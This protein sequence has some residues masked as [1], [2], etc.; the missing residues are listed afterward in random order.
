M[1]F[2]KTLATLAAGFAA[3]RGV[4]QFRRMGGMDGVKEALRKAGDPGGLADDMAAMAEKAGVP[5]GAA[6]V[7][8]WSARAS[9]S[10]LGGIAAAEMGL[11][12][13]VSV[14]ARAAGT[15]AGAA[16]ALAGAA[17]PVLANLTE[18]ESKLMIRAMAEAA[19]A[20]GQIDDEE[21]RRLMD[22][23]ADADPAERAY[24]EGLLAAPADMAGLVAATGEAMKARVYAASLLAMRADTAAERAYLDQLAAALGLD[25][26]AR[27]ALDA[28]AAGA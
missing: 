20:D 14:L 11:G 18:A 24:V 4:D 5:G 7:R 10:A 3:A 21:A 8:D 9:G 2:F 19:K 17:S 15:Q 13:L 27:A 25:A 22:L 1:S 6:A 12:N 23:L 26:D 28:P 16:G